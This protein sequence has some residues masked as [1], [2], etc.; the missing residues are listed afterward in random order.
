MAKRWFLLTV[1]LLLL[2]SAH[3]AFALKVI[4]ADAFYIYFPEEAAPLGGRLAQMCGPM[5][6]FLEEQGIPV[7][8]PLHILIDAELDQPRAITRL[9]P[10][11]EIRLPLRA[12][13]A[14]EDGYT[15]PDPWRYFLFKGLCTLGICN[16]RSG[17]PG[18]L[19]CVLGEIISPNIILP[20]WAIDGV[21]HLLYEHYSHRRV[22]DPMADAVFNTTAI[23]GLDKVSHHPEIWPGRFSFRIYGRPF[24]QW[25][26][27]RFGWEKMLHFIQLHGRGI[28]PIEIDLKAKR[29]FG[30]TWNQLWRM[31]QKE[32]SAGALD[33]DGVPISGYWDAPYYYWNEIGVYP[34]VVQAGRRGRYGYVDDQNWLWLSEY[35]EGV[36]KIKIQR[37]A[38]L[39]HAVQKHVWDPGPG[40]VAVSRH[41]YQPVI[42]VFGPRHGSGLFEGMEETLPVQHEIAGPAGILQMS[43]PVMDD[44]GRIAVAANTGGNWDIWL[45]DDQWYRITHTPSIDIDPWWSDGKLIFS[46]NA[47]GQFQIHDSHME[48]LTHATTA[49]MLPRNR[50]YLQLNVKGWQRKT[51]SGPALPLLPETLAESP[52]PTSKPESGSR[53][54][55]AYSVWK[56]IWPNYIGPDFFFNNEEFQLGLSTRGTDVSRAHTWNAGVRYDVNEG[57][58]TCRLGYQVNE[59]S[60]R[61]IRYPLSYAPQRGTAIDEV[62]YEVN[63]AWSPSMLKELTLAANWRR[64]APEDDRNASKE[65]WWGNIGWKD[66]V[67]S[68]QTVVNLDVFNDTSHSLYGELLYWFGEKVNT[69]MRLQGGKTWGDLNPGHNTFRIGGN[70][71][72]GYFTQRSSRLFALR[73][74]D[75]NILDADQA[76]SASMD[77]LWPFA[78]LQTGY[79]TLPLF[80][81]NWTLDAFVDAGF[82][83][84]QFDADELLVSAGIEL[85]TGMEMAWARKSSFSIGLAWSLKK[86]DDIDQEGPVLLILIGRPL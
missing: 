51:I 44:K 43:G 32:R 58:V 13:G 20:E 61:A 74:F 36:S 38:E 70:T 60:T 12:P 64:Y 8:K 19:H 22:W 46:S 33:G 52:K 57:Q 2:G 71:G 79:K 48:P 1:V 31:F 50:T 34:G 6:A 75:S 21:S 68:V 47:S 30:K 7:H 15:E 3:S 82:A 72:E 27:E 78:R 24:I 85:I 23:P 56:S 54:F 77:V 63:V 4:E 42:V 41:G 65:A 16:E 83:S 10:H 11:R 86:P 76:A 28:I 59:L 45:Y 53:D 73:G 25:L 29:A 81:H 17:L 69:I 5:A 80:L 66:T 84:H 40:S 55:K 9:Y 67:G 35:I 49:A 18:G 14:L 39:R 26:Y 37:R 62:R